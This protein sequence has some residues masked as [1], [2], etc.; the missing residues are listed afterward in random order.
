MASAVSP[1]DRPRIARQFDMK[2]TKGGT[3]TE[4]TGVSSVGMG[5]AIGNAIDNKWD[6]P[7]QDEYFNKLAYLQVGF[8]ETFNAHGVEAVVT[9]VA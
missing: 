6:D 5:K 2:I 7:T 9:G 1:T 3:T 4:I 8:T